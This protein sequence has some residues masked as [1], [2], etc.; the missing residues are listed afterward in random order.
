M[1]R[2]ALDHAIRR[3]LAKDSEERWQTARDVKLELQWI[4]EG[5]SQ[6]GVP[7]PVI[8]HRKVRERLTQAATAI[9]LL[10]AIA[11]AIG[12]VLRA[13]KPPQPGR[14]SAEIGADANLGTDIRP[15][16]ILS[17]DGARL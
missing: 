11:F 9:F 14:L 8:S 5:G 13:P 2:P 10:A 16:A 15:A 12:F 6:A 7:A 4:A 3:C 17:P 1:T